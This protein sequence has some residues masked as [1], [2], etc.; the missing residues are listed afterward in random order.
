M[1][2]DDTSRVSHL[3]GTIKFLQVFDY[4]YILLQPVRCDD[5][6]LSVTSTRTVMLLQVFDYRYILLQCMCNN[7]S[8]LSV[9]LTLTK[10]RFSRV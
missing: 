7:N 5:N 8:I 1:C 10:L 2:S 3:Q 4:M 9:T 6:T